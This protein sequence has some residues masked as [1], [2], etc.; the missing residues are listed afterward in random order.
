[1]GATGPGAVGVG[2][3]MLKVRVPRLPK[4]MPAPGRASAVAEPR[5]SAQ[6]A[7]ITAYL[8][9]DLVISLSPRRLPVQ[10]APLIWGGP[11][12][13][14]RGME[15]PRPRCPGSGTRHAMKPG[16]SR[17]AWHGEWASDRKGAIA[18]LRRLGDHDLRPAGR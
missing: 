8:R 18:L 11:V 6:I 14:P 13:V 12:P 9:A 5:K 7:A 2:P 10:G 3:G 17:L 16:R 4:L 1:M 15:K